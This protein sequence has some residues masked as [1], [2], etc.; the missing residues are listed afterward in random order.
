MFEPV[1]ATAVYPTLAGPA[2]AAGTSHWRKL[3][4]ALRE[5]ELLVNLAHEAHAGRLRVPLD[6]LERAG[7]DMN[8]LGKLPWP[9]ALTTLLRERHEALRG[10]IAKS[11]SNVGRGQTHFRGLIVWSALV[12]RLS[13]RAQR[14]L[15]N[16]IPPRRYHALADGWQA[17]RAAHRATAG[18]L[19]LS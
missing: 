19:R 13:R 11:L 3:G 4:A 14:A 18:N 15:P 12:W 1:A 10:T 2:A 9:A 16:T 7:V 17:W 5:V 8:S 6:E